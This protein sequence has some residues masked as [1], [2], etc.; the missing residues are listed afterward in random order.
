MCILLIDFDESQV[1]F[2][3]GMTDSGTGLGSSGLGEWNPDEER[4]STGNK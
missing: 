2:E 1:Q 4:I 3:D